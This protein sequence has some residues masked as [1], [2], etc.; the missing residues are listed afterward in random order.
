MILAL[1]QSSEDPAAQ[2]LGIGAR[3]LGPQ[4]ALDFLIIVS[5]TALNFQRFLM[6][7]PVSGALGPQAQPSTIAS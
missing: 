1:G 5:S 7:S 6:S 4:T 2:H 3:G